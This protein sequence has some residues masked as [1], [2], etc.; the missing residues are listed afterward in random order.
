MLSGDRGVWAVLP[1]EPDAGGICRGPGVLGRH[2]HR[3]PNHPQPAQEF[4][5]QFA[6]RIE[7]TCVKH[8][9]GK[10]S[11]QMYYKFAA[12]LRIENTIQRCAFSGS[13]EGGTQERPTYSRAGS[14]GQPQLGRDLRC[15]RVVTGALPCPPLGAGRLLR[16]SSHARRLTIKPHAVDGKTVNFFA[17]ANALLLYGS[18]RSILPAYAAPTCC[19]CW[20]RAHHTGCRRNSAGCSISACSGGDRHIPILPDANRSRVPAGSPRRSSLWRRSD[21]NF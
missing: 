4:G 17:S 18:R 11:I 1:L 6:T 20:A 12:E 2:L 15:S 21:G 8:R 7:G 19:R 9:F 16:R 13:Q 10:A 3:P 14:Q 5:S